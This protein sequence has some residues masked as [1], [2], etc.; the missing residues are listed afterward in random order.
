MYINNIELID[1]LEN[2]IGFTSKE[3]FLSSAL[4]DLNKNLNIVR[5]ELEDLIKA[6]KK[7]SNNFNKISE[8]AKELYTQKV[9]DTIKQYK[10]IRKQISIILD[11]RKYNNI[12]I[13][14]SFLEKLSTFQYYSYEYSIEENISDKTFITPLKDIMLIIADLFDVDNNSKFT[15]LFYEIYSYNPENDN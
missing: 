4:N 8:A 13:I 15:D 1:L 2:T 14:K 11:K 10:E 12:S 5:K 9:E 7:N 3:R 6:R